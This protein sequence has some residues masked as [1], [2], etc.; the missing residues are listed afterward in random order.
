[1]TPSKAFYEFDIMLVKAF[2]DQK[3]FE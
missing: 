3:T 1:V 2:S